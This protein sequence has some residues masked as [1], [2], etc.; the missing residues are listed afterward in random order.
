ML[1][2]CSRNVR[3]ILDSK[4]HLFDP[5]KMNL[6]VIGLLTL[7]KDSLYT[8]AVTKKPELLEQEALSRLFRFKQGHTML[9]SKFLEQFLE[10]VEVLKH[11]GTRLG[12]ED[13]KI[14]PILRSI[15][16]DAL[17]P[18]NAEVAQARSI[19][20]ERYFAILVIQSTDKKRYG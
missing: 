15:T 18:T 20:S 9:D 14:A 6:D 17:N 8:G 2:Q 13:S 10:L 1:V 11:L 5:I 16:Y 7:I 12:E 3:D 4:K 19:A